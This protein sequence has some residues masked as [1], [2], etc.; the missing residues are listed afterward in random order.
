MNDAAKRGGEPPLT[1]VVLAGGLSSRMGRDKA[2]MKLMRGEEPDLLARAANVLSSCCRRV[3]VVGRAHPV[4]ESYPDDIPGG[5]PVGGIATALEKARGP[6]LVL[7]CDLPFMEKKVVQR[8]AA[9]RAGRPPDSLAT[10]YRQKDTGHVEALVA[11]Y[12]YAALPF[13]QQCAREKRLKI[14]L[15]IPQ[16]RQHFLEYEIDEALPFFNV[17]YP[18]DLI[19]A[20]KIMQMMGR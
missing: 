3:I 12:E 5:G 9:C 6:C 20:R 11:I 2:L 18:A 8:L 14:S 7:S 16:A 15:V 1:G 10:L 19:V 4:H 17:N 13:F